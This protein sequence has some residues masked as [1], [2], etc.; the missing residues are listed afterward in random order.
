[1]LGV[2]GEALIFGRQTEIAWRDG[3][4]IR[5]VEPEDGSQA[6]FEIGRKT[7]MQLTPGAYLLKTD[8]GL[9]YSPENS[10]WSHASL[11]TILQKIQQLRAVSVQP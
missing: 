6:Y 9:F 1:M 11:D 3:N 10:D 4:P 5:L 7:V 8:D 2:G